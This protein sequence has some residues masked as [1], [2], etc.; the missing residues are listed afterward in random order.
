[1]DLFRVT[2]FEKLKRIAEQQALP[3]VSYRKFD[4]D[5]HEGSLLQALMTNDGLKDVIKVLKE[6]EENPS[7]ALSF[8][9]GA[10]SAD[11]SAYMQCWTRTKE[12]NLMWERYGD[13]A[14][15]VRMRMTEAGRSNMPKWITFHEARYNEE[16]DIWKELQITTKEQQRVSISTVLTWQS[17]PS[18]LMLSGHIDFRESLTFKFDAYKHEDEVRLMT[19]ILNDLT[20]PGEEPETPPWFN[21]PRGD[22]DVTLIPIGDIRNVIASIMVGPDADYDLK[23][24]VEKFCDEFGLIYEGKSL[25]KTRKYTGSKKIFTADPEDPK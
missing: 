17:E 15:A 14:N 23:Q 4:D 11:A 1:M 6:H 24:N 10:R 16:F 20:S 9:Q 12:H 5:P 7:L 3:F 18:K 19:P 8:I 13:G 21:N 2:S 25:L 22:K